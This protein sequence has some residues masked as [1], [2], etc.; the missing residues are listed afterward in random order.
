MLDTKLKK[1]SY[2]YS[3]KIIAFV[4]AITTFT[5]A[6]YIVFD[7]IVKSNG[8]I[9]PDM[10]FQDNYYESD[11]FYNDV[12]RITGN[13]SVLL[14]EYKNKEYINAGNSI[15]ENEL[16]DNT[17]N[18]YYQ[19][20]DESK[21]YN[22]N[23][24]DNENREIFREEYKAQIENIKKNMIEN[25]LRRYNLIQNVLDDYSG[26]NYFA[27]DGTNTFKNSNNTSIKD[28]EEY[29][30]YI[31]IENNN[32]Q[33]TP[34]EISNGDNFW[35]LNNY[36]NNIDLTNDKIYLGFTDNYLRT[37]IDEWR[38]NKNIIEEKSYQVLS[39]SLIFLISFIY[40]IYSIGRKPEDDDIHLSGVDKIYTDI[41]IVIEFSLIALWTIFWA[42]PHNNVSIKLF[43]PGTVIIS[44]L[45]LILL[46]SLVKHIKRKTIIKHSV[47]YIIFHKIFSFFKEVYNN[48]NIAV[49]IILIVIGYP[50]LVVATFFMFPITIG[51]AAYLVLRK[52][53]EFNSIKEGVKRIKDGE[54]NHEIN[55]E[56]KGEFS[57]LANDIN[58]IA[59]GLNQA[60]ENEVKSERLKSELISNVSHDIRTPLTSIITYVDLL[61]REEHDEQTSEYID[62]L[63]EKSQKL[64]VLTDDLF[65]ASKANSG[66]I[67]VNLEK[68]N[69][70]SLITQGIG[71]LDYKVKESNLEFKMNYKSEKMYVMA[72]GKLLWRSIEN[73]F[74]N[75]FKYAVKNSRVYIDI[76][77]NDENIYLTIKNISAYE[78]NISPDELME[79]FKRGDE[80][81]NSPGSGLGLSIAKSLIELQGGE[82]KIQIDGDL[83]KVILKLNRA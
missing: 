24:S 1:F 61:K 16:E 68:I 59:D 29:P 23:L 69:L 35:R 67:P 73:L 32:V 76:I 53:K 31:L 60:V 25:D 6:L 7:T 48:G 47:T 49:K 5:A 62:V 77:E 44:T 20:V 65:E 2:S 66:N 58:S 36:S 42:S 72:D 56:S 10:L 52:I 82:F 33:V 22:P 14:E 74:S 17:E 50:L 75:V 46:L 18:L 26:I 19:F 21:K 12:E 54:L 39:L 40:L 45:G 81:R 30:S 4:L 57:R 63:D 9:N 38:S 78:L 55:I 27:S 83:F 8:D 79:R 51:I 43:I 11:D 15:N 71:E 70:V 80:S 13:L 3:L 28:F 64:K 41:N 37:E 34:E